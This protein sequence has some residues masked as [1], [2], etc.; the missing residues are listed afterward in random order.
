MILKLLL[1]YPTSRLR[2]SVLNLRHSN[3]RT[4][5]HGFDAVNVFNTFPLISRSIM[6][7]TLQCTV[8]CPHC[9]HSAR[10]TMPTTFCQFFY[11]C[12]SCHELLNAKEG[13][14]CVFCSYGNVPCPSSQDSNRR[15]HATIRRTHAPIVALF[16]L[17]ILVIGKVVSSRVF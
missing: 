10:E 1:E 9:G 8:D 13:D 6:P 7:I 17:A 16:T 3:R 15:P 12:T 14:C 4:W 2:S 11:E 5:R